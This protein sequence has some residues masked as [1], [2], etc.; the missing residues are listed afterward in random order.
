MTCGCAAELMLTAASYGRSTGDIYIYLARTLFQS[1][2][3]VL[4]KHYS[5]GH[6]W[7]APEQSMMNSNSLD[8][9]LL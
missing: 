5:V 1:S 9:L 7:D 8:E 4:F 2:P 3:F 6:V